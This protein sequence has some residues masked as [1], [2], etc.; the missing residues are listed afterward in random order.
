MESKDK[1][2]SCR[3]W[4]EVYISGALLLIITGLMSVNWYHHDKLVELITF[5][6]T[7][8]SLLLALIA[9]G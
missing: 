1:P 5:A 3:G 9:I 8:S 6:A 4:H 7:V 2:C